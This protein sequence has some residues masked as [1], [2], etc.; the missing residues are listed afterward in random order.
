MPTLWRRLSAACLCL[1]PLLVS[2]SGTDTTT[3]PVSPSPVTP[4]SQWIVAWGVS[5]QNALTTAANPGGAEQS[6]RFLVLPS[7]AGTQERVHFSNYFGTT[8]ITIGAARLAV[9]LSGL[10]SAI[11]STHDAPLT[12]SGSSTVTLQPKQEIDSDPVK[13]TYTFG[14]WLA[15]SMYL[16]GSFPALTEHNS[17]I[18]NNY[19]TAAGAGHTLGDATGAAFTQTN[20]EWYLVTGVEAYGP[21][22]GTVAFFGSSSV[23]GHNANFG[24][25]NSYP[26][27]NVAIPTQIDQR[28]TDWLAKSL[29]AAGYSVGVVNAGLLGDPAGEDATTA[30]GSSTAG[31]DRIDH[32]VLQLPGIKAV[33]V[34]IG[35]IDLR[36]DCTTAENVEASLTTIVAKAHAAGVRVILGTIPPAEYCLSAGPEPSAADPYAGDLNPGPENSGSTQR[37]AVNTWIRTLGAQLPGVV[38]VADFDT[39]LAYPAHPDFFLPNL[40]SNDN[41]HPNGAGYGVQNSAIPLGSLLGP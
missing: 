17:Q 36:G 4:A 26:T 30:S 16:Q 13:I 5:P 39:V 37:R 9:A 8:P 28:P 19:A 24:A 21:Y 41:F 27:P 20:Q 12:F 33:V 3:V 1:L 23:D 11:D 6:F 38:A 29:N 10:G 7:V 15:V 2:C 25:T 35:G 40:Y 18:S 22:G 31:V 14:Q 34:Y 32:D